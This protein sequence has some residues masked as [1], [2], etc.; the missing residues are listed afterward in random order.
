MNENPELHLECWNPIKKLTILFRDSKVYLTVE[1]KQELDALIQALKENKMDE[2]L[3]IEL[4]ED[5]IDLP[6]DMRST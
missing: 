6:E 3:T 2:A 1:I 4:F 5:D